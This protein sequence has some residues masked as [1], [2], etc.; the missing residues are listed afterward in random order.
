MSLTLDFT[1]LVSDPCVP[2]VLVLFFFM[3]LLSVSDAIFIFL[4]FPFL[5]FKKIDVCLPI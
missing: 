2:S 4:V 3:N 1:R 5:F